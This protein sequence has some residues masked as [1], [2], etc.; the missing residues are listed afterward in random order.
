MRTQARRVLAPEVAY[1]ANRTTNASGGM[2]VDC[3][4]YSPGPLVR[5]GSRAS[6]VVP[7]V[8]VDETLIVP[9]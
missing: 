2:S 5:R 9:P 4:C 1:V 8:A 6:N 3:G 7:S